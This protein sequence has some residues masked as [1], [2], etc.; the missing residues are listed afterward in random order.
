MEVHAARYA[1][2][3]ATSKCVN[4]EMSKHR[5]VEMWKPMVLLVRECLPHFSGWR[6]MAFARVSRRAAGA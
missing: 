1:A 5:N 6:T 3:G 2:C 4:V